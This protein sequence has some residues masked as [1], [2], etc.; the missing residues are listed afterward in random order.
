MDG[1]GE[2]WA[3]LRGRPAADFLA[4]ARDAVAAV[5]LF[6]QFPRNMFRGTAEAFATDP[7]ALAIAKGAL[8][9]GYEEQLSEGERSFLYMP[10]MHSEDLADQ[11]RSAALFEA[12]GW[13]DPAKFARLHRDMIA[14][15][16]RFPARNAALGREDRPG[17]DE[18]I[19]ASREW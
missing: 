10:L 17:E 7:L 11:D 3:R 16:G 9:R 14:R 12:L 15:Y 19:A 5:V 2:T 8:D 6:D 1:F 18:G 4:T 13:A